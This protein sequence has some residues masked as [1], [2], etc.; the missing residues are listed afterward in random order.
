MSAVDAFYV[1]QAIHEG[2]HT[3]EWARF[4]DAYTR[5]LR[6]EVENPDPEAGRAFPLD[7]EEVGLDFLASGNAYT[8]REK[9]VL[10]GSETFYV[11]PLMSRLVTAA[12]EEWPADEPVTEEDWPTDKGFLYVPGGVS[13]L[14]IRG[15]V[16]TTV[17]FAWERRGDRTTVTWW[18]DKQYDHPY[19]KERPGWDAMP[20]FSPWHVVTLQHGTP[21]PTGLTMGTVIPPEVGQH[22]QWIKAPDGALAL[23]FP[24]GWSPEQL[25][26]H[27]G[28]DR[29][30]AW[31][32]S[33]LRIMQQPLAAL[34]QQ[35]MPANVR[36]QFKRLPARLRLKQKPVTVIDF[37]RRESDFTSHGDREYTHRFLRRG[38][39]RRQ[40]YKRDDGTWDR[41]RIWIHAT[42]VGDPSLPLILR[43]HVNA[44]TR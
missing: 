22:M 30:S 27:I 15:Q 29:V 32:V 34:G 33:A 40:P 10:A 7:T 28:V 42:V 25:R 12:A 11:A 38:H 16:Q 43:N 9:R 2:L 5:S 20:Q 1:K 31:L 18:T 14:D 39:W 17:A 3:I 19:T 35:G 13:T 44:L 8:A 26:P 37:R 6:G 4:A 36:A 24:Q 41:R 21:L 23:T